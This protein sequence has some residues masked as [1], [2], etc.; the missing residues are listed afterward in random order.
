MPRFVD[1]VSALLLG[2][3]SRMAIPLAA[4]VGLLALGCFS[5]PDLL[6]KGRR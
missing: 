2:T 5:Q 4:S 1:A 3:K 6:K